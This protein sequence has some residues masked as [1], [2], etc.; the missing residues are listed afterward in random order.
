VFK[1][2]DR[3]TRRRTHTVGGLESALDVASTLPSPAEAVEAAEAR[4]ELRRAIRTLPPAEQQVVLLYYLGDRSHAEIARFLGITPNAVKTRLYS[5]RRHL[6]T[7]MSR[8][9]KGLDAARPSADSRFVEKV[10]R[11]IQPEALKRQKPW[12]WSPGIGTDVWEM[13]VACITGDLDAVRAL[14]QRDPSLVRAHY[15]YRTPLSFA[16]RENHLHV[17]EYL[18]DNGAAE[19]F[20]GD[21]LEMARDRGLDA[22]VALLERKYHDSH[23]ASTRGEPVAEAIRARDIEAV[24]SLLDDDSSLVRARDQRSNEPI[25]WATMTRQLDVIDELVRRGADLN[26]RRGDNALPIHLTNGDYH[27]RGWRDVPP[28]VT[29]TPDDVY[30]HLVALGADVDIGMAAFQGD[31]ARVR[32]LLAHDASLANAT[33]PYNSYYVGCGAPLK[34][35]AAGGNVEIVKLLLA[36]GADPNEPEEGIAPRGHALYAAVYNGN[37]TIAKLLLEHGAF[38]NPPVESSADAVWIAI[39]RGDRRMLELLGTHGAVMDVPIALDGT[40]TYDDLVA[41]GVQL[42]LR[43]LAF[44]GDTRRLATRL[45]EDSTAA[46]DAEALT[47]AAQHGHEEIVRLLLEYAPSLAKRVTVSKPREMAELLFAHGMD[48]DRPNWMRATPLHHFARDGDIESAALFLDHGADLTARDEEHCSTPLAWAARN[49]QTRMVEFL[50]RRGAPLELP[51]DP[52]WATP[53]VWASRRGYEDVQQLLTEYQRTGALPHRSF[54]EVELLVRDLANAYTGNERALR[55]I[56]RHF[57]I[58]RHLTWDRPS[59]DVQVARLQR[60]IDERLQHIPSVA[61]RTSAL[62]LDD[63]RLLIALSEGFATWTDL[64]DSFD[65]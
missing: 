44:Y 36:H 50:L 37:Y 6:R 46:E 52:P 11:L 32:E 56:V 13:F 10:R 26:A 58:E 20:L 30:R 1:H 42:P 24:R 45:R 35:A 15:E 64:V 57:R 16:V 7:H 21:P 22:M 19:V 54:A 33:S 28:R 49:R 27:Y 29:T 12:M 47:A 38:P 4:D 2:C 41:T 31:E 18:L 51:D 60:A 23:G 34:N 53:L 40:L 62:S 43:I 8:I 17:A 65:A 55:R 63:A 25:H 61:L 3:I 14:V 59:L 9:E 5:A 48:P 39:R